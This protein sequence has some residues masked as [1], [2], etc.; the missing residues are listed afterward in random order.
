MGRDDQGS[1]REGDIIGTLFGRPEEEKMKQGGGKSPRAT[2]YSRTGRQSATR[3][4][5]EPMSCWE[6]STR[7]GM[8]TMCGNNVGS[9]LSVYRAYVDC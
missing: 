5:S 7:E 9:Q 1:Y 3:A 6:V 2:V 8:C 4:G